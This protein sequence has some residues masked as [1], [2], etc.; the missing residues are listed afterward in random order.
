[1]LACEHGGETPTKCEGEV[2]EYY[3]STNFS[4]PYSVA[5]EDINFC[6]AHAKEYQ[7]SDRKHGRLCV[8]PDES[9]HPED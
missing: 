9:T 3:F 8:R 7:S 5:S 6:A 2:V 1:M 4:G